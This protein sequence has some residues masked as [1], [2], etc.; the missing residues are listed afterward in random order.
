MLLY[1]MVGI[2]MDKQET[3]KRLEALI[4]RYNS[5]IRNQDHKDISEETI[6]TWLNEMLVIFGWNVQDSSQVLQERVLDDDLRRKL[7]SIDSTHTRPDYILKNGQ[8][9]KTFFCIVQFVDTNTIV[10]VI[11]CIIDHLLSNKAFVFR[12]YY[13]VS[14][15]PYRSFVFFCY[16]FR[17]KP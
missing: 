9:I 5:T 4:Q 11:D 14:A 7:K 15:I 16:F 8:N 6:R 13:S 12:N 17:I 1:T 10:Y 3:K 2:S